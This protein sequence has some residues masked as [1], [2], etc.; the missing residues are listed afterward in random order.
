MKGEYTGKDGLKHRPFLVPD[1]PNNQALLTT[2]P[3][4]DL[5]LAALAPQATEGEAKP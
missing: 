5:A 2:D 1:N 3:D 4:F